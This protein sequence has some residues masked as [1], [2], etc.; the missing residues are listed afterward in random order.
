[1]ILI[2]G[3]SGLVGK[4]LSKFFDNNHIEYIGTYNTNVINKNNMFKVNLGN[5]E[6]LE[7]FLI[8]HK[9]TY[10][11]F[12][13]VERLTDK[14]ENNWN[15][16]RN[17]N[18]D[19][20]N[21][22]SFLCNKLNIKFIH[23]S[24]DYV[25]DGLTQPNKPESPKNPLQ[26]YGISKLVSEYRV[27]KNCN[28]FC[29][30]R[31]PVLY[32]SLSKIHDNAVSL[33]GKNIMDLRNNKCFKEDNYSIRR[34]LYIED[35][36][37]FIND[38]ID[39]PSGIYHFYNPHNKF[40]K[41]E[42]SNI[43]SKYLGFQNNIKPVSSIG[44]SIA[45]RPYDTQLIDNNFDISKYS[46]KNFNESIELCFRKFKHPKINKSS[47][48]DYF[49]L[50]DLDG[51]IIDSSKAHYNA[52]VKTFEKYGKN[53]ISFDEWNDIILNDNI[54]NYLKKCFD[55]KMISEVKHIKLLNLQNETIDFTKNSQFFIEYLLENNFNFCMVTNT[56]EET[57]SHFKEKLPILKCIKNWI[58]RENYNLQKPDPEPYKL[59]INTYY[60]NEKYIIGI[61]DSLVG[62]RSVS[63]VT[64]I[65]YIYDNEKVFSNNDCFLFDDF[66]KI[67]ENN[68]NELLD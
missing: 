63:A 45:P 32:S 28:N 2:C 21:I 36:C 38:C 65:I 64:N 66:S 18:I 48:K 11:I 27:L 8:Q 33:I 24:T 19:L 1:M 25:F 35:L 41:Y 59:A 62:F 53:F 12:C 58:Y 9:I 50:I 39:K 54:D 67:V 29:I 4:E 68:K 55:A 52:Y 31:T 34:P 57:V 42:M 6:E 51:T 56:T 15:E 46:F 3:A 20:V 60:N 26:N 14:C 17:T 40:T 43:I 22:A 30:I 37:C 7:V 49:L 5:H 13:V 47:S 16:I 61:E 10:C 44:D 23:L